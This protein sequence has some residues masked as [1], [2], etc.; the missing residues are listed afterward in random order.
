M[1]I[2]VPVILLFE[3][4]CR[5]QSKEV[6]VVTDTGVSLL[7]SLPLCSLGDTSSAQSTFC[8][9]LVHLGNVVLSPL[10]NLKLFPR[11]V[12][13]NQSFL[14]SRSTALALLQ[15]GLISEPTVSQVPFCRTPLA[16]CSAHFLT[17]GVYHCPALL[18]A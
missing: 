7:Y 14:G 8:I 4:S 16:C 17:H 1:T 12:N 10:V 13:S 3:R 11:T 6:V 9:Y 15:C 5:L 2:P 18:Q